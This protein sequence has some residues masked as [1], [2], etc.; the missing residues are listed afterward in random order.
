MMAGANSGHRRA[1][2]R[3]SAS[4]SREPV[5][6]RAPRARAVRQGAAHPQRTCVGC[7]GVAA[8][9]EMVRLVLGS[10]GDVLPDLAGKA[11]GRGAWVH[12]RPDCV[13]RGVPRGVARSWR[14]TVRS[15]AAELTL[16]VRAAASR[17]IEGLLKSAGRSR[18]LAVGSLAVRG[19]LE[20]GQAELVVVAVDAQ[21]SADSAWVRQAVSAGQAV[22]WGTK[23]TLGDAVGRGQAGVVAVLHDRLARELRRS[24]ALAHLGPPRPE[25]EAPSKHPSTEDR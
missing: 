16:A 17:R 24:V 7:R 4:G 23:Q 6:A 14:T 1:D 25:R 5:P 22:A 21:A 15:S 18:Q 3:A 9:R 12:P 2:R 11:F 13:A 20:R 10:D 19:A 8:P